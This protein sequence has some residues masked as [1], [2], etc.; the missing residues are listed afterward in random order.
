MRMEAI[1][2]LFDGPS[3]L[4]SDAE[5]SKDAQDAIEKMGGEWST[6]IIGPIK[7]K[8]DVGEKKYTDKDFGLRAAVAIPGRKNT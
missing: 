1:S 7:Q 4:L 2:F 6:T 3:E 5:V 8:Q